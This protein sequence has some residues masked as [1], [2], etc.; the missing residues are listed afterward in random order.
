MHPKEN[1]LG[2]LN[3]GVTARSRD[4]VSNACFFSK[5]EP[6]N[7]KEAL[8]GEYWIEAMQE[9]LGSSRGMKFGNLYLDLMM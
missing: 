6:K 1:I 7:C 5:V 2:N 9:E 3:E 4:I 8:T